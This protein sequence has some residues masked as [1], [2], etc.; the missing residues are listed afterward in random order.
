MSRR[1]RDAIDELVWEAGSL[2][3][4]SL[5]LWL[6][7]DM[8][9]SMAEAEKLVNVWRVHLRDAWDW[10]DLTRSDDGQPWCNSHYARQLILWSIPLA[11]SGQQYSAPQQKLSFAP[12]L[13]AP[14]RLPWFTPVANGVLERTAAGK[15]RLLTLSGRAELRELTIAGGTPRKD[16]LLEAGRAVELSGK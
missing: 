9:T 7:E 5:N 1:G 12:R 15:Y 4:T 6:G 16:V 14:A 8:K 13:G 2:D 3:W 11:L 10:R